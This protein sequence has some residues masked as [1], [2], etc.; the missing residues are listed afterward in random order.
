MN[1]KLHY[2]NISHGPQVHCYDCFPRGLMYILVSHIQ[3]CVVY[4]VKLRHSGGLDQLMGVAHNRTCARAL[5]TSRKKAAV[6][7]RN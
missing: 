2:T 7:Y 1:S 6:D 3:L 4:V 5:Q